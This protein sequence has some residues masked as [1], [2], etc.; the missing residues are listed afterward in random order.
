MEWRSREQTEVIL[1]LVQKF[2]PG[3]LVVWPGSFSSSPI[4]VWGWQRVPTLL[5]YC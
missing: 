3:Q 4:G 2:L 1:A 5:C